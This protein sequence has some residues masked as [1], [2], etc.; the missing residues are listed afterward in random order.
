MILCFARHGESEANISRTF[1]NR[2]LPHRL[3]AAGVEHAH[4][5][6]S[7]FAQHGVTR[8]CCSPVPRAVDTAAIIASDLGLCYEVTE[9]LRE[10]DVGRYEGTSDNTGWEE[11]AAVVRAWLAGSHEQRVGG[12]ESLTEVVDRLAGFL[13]TLR[14]TARDNS[15]IGLIGHGGLYRV[16]LP[17]VLT[18][19]TP[20]FAFENT[21]GYGRLIVAETRG[22][23]LVC[24]EWDGRTPEA[25]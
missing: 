25:A 14:E 22:V 6:A 1:S 23:D 8:L 18:G 13:T 21:L 17:H 4:Q 5:L 15:V 9:G 16:A 2:D 10:F 24:V 20:Q 19:V 11:Y 3:T 7:L 12:G